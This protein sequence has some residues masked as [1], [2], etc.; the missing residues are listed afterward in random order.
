MGSPFNSSGG[1]NPNMRAFPTGKAGQGI[2][3]VRSNVWSDNM[4]FTVI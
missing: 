2:V 3:Y 1:K 4:V